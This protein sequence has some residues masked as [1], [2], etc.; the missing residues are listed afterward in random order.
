MYQELRALILSTTAVYQS[1]IEPAKSLLT[2][3]GEGATQ[4]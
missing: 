4:E 3:G 1:G 2:L